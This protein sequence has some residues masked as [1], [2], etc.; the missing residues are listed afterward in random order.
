MHLTSKPMK[1]ITKPMKK[2]KK[3][4]LAHTLIISLLTLGSQTLTQAATGWDAWSADVT[5]SLAPYVQ[6]G[7]FNYTF[8]PDGAT[9]VYT[10]FP[11]L[12]N[13]IIHP[14]GT[15]P[16]QPGTADFPLPATLEFKILMPDVS[17]VIGWGYIDTVTW[18]SI[19]YCATRYRTY[20]SAAP[21]GNIVDDGIYSTFSGQTFEAMGCPVSICKANP[22]TLFYTI[23]DA[24]AGGHIIVGAKTDT[25]VW[26][27]APFAVSNVPDG[28]PWTY[29]GPAGANSTPKGASAVDPTDPAT[30]IFKI[31]AV[32]LYAGNVQ[33]P[34]PPTR[35]VAFEDDFTGAAGTP[36]DASKWVFSTE[37][38]PNGGLQT[39]LLD[40]NGGL[41]IT[42]SQGQNGVDSSFGSW[43]NHISVKPSLVT[44]TLADEPQL[45]WLANFSNNGWTGAGEALQGF[46]EPYPPGSPSQAFYWPGP[47]RLRAQHWSANPLDTGIDLTRDHPVMDQYFRITL[48]ADGTADY[49]YK[50]GAAGTW[51][52]LS[53]NTAFSGGPADQL[54]P[55]FM[56]GWDDMSLGYVRL[57]I[58][59]RVLQG[60]TISHSRSGNTLTLSW[61]GGGA[62][63]EAD[64]VTGPWKTVANAASPAN[65]TIAAPRKFYRIRQ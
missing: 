29:S 61:P 18:G 15:A 38:A 12:A 41:L 48:H 8:G 50:D 13:P 28:G 33:A 64:E 22:V 30:V 40:G 24:G 31:Q 20:D 55:Y 56:S 53:Q 4:M 10:G 57:S 43:H 46:G 47:N 54:V 11:T 52:M 34:P 32:H 65:L 63:E 62:L 5:T 36:V 9:G 27:S 37:S 49:E 1:K 21:G 16:I 45:E 39:A 26:S 7:Q 6:S 44:W 42:G 14:M 58:L 2:I 19:Y 51:Q 3:A 17:C 35:Q 59:A 25:E 60:P 23:V